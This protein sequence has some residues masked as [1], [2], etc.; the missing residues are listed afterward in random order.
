MFSLGQLTA[1]QLAG[2]SA[3]TEIIIFLSYILICAAL[4]KPRFS[5]HSTALA[6]GAAG[7]VIA[8][9]NA[10][11]MLSGNETLML[12]LTL[13]PLTAYLPF[14]VMLYFISDG[15]LFETAAVCSAGT[16]VVLI[17]NA[18]NKTAF[19]VLQHNK[20]ISAHNYS[21]ITNFVIAL[22]GA[23]IVFCAFRF[24]GKAFRFCVIENKQNRLMLSIPIIM[25]F[26]MMF[27]FLNSTTNII[28]LL[29]LS[30]IALSLFFIIAR[31]LNSTAELMRVR[32]SEKDLSEYIDVQRRG[33]DRVAQ[34]M[35]IIRE[36]RHDMRHH[37]T[38]IEGLLKQDDS[39]KALDYISQLNDSFGEADAERYCV[40]PEIN[41]VMSEYA[42]RAKN[43]G[44]KITQKLRL[45][46]T[47]PFEASDVCIILA[48]V[49]EN[50][51]NACRE[52]PE[53]KCYINVSA[54]Y[55]NDRRLM[56]LVE[57][58]C[59]KSIE[60]D[61]SNLPVMENNSD[62]H[63]IGL[64]S[65]KRIVEKYNG[66]MRCMLDNG[67]FVFQTVLFYDNSN[68]K[69][70]PK[71]RT[72]ILNKITTS[73]LGL[74][75]CII[76]LLNVM[77]SVAEATGALLSVNIRT[78]RSFNFGWGDNSLSTDTPE[79][80][81]NGAEELN[82]SVQNYTD[83]AKDKFW[84][85]FNR[86]YNGYVGEDMQYTVIRDDEKYFIARFN[87]TINAGGSMDYSRWITFDK[88]A[89]K[90]LE[91]SDL[92]AADV[93]YVSILSAE[94]L[95]QMKYINEHE[96]GGFF[97][98]GDDAFTK[99]NED[100]NFY[101]DSF[102]RLVVVFDEYEVAPGFMGSPEFYIPKELL[103]TNVR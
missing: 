79:F 52:L 84:W 11:I 72:K 73:I 48:N 76:I 21:I 47:L 10:V 64:R 103:E 58:P 83:E 15:G 54:E 16:L 78:I 24:I 46:E 36:H 44:C 25:I 18:L 85:Y 13:L 97:V 5:R 100:V 56:L 99:I 93:D 26:L 39:D 37:L 45:P 88:A 102:D 3:V 9:L 1:G 62:E 92:F 50:A 34:K 80:D 27:W 77:P 82:S 63:G 89:G 67:E 31:L 74:F 53:E 20:S 30:A 23:V 55:V 14:S 98:E 86:R 17:L 35:E 68:P 96:G 22:V 4:F 8:A 90:V 91:L 71:T 87:V 70:K 95:E 51:I 12:M 2:S 6:F 7:I 60:F 38:V 41:A 57:N 94:I 32:R 19:A 42:A 28:M 65:V 101:I 66:I 69:N 33:Y 29:S 40:N 59:E 75:S 81:G 49:I 43:A 61:E